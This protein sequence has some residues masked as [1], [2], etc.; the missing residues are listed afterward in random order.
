MATPEDKIEEGYKKFIE[1]Y[2]TVRA[3]VIVIFLALIIVIICKTRE[4]SK[5]SNEYDLLKSKH[6]NLQEEFDTYK[7]NVHDEE[8]MHE[9]IVV[10]SH[11]VYH[12]LDCP[13]GTGTDS[14]TLM[15]L[16]EALDSGYESCDECNP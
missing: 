8:S 15:P 13:L 7:E 1:G 16:D 5:L 14:F 11:G 9:I 3:G 10:V 4:Y 6:Q 12:S 2:K